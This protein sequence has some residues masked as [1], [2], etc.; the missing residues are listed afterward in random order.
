M[1]YKGSGGVAKKVA[2]VNWGK[3]RIQKKLSEGVFIYDG[4]QSGGFVFYLPLFKSLKPYKTYVPARRNGDKT[5]FFEDEQCY[6]VFDYSNDTMVPFFL[7][8]DRV[9][10]ESFYKF[11]HN[12]RKI[13]KWEYE[14]WKQEQYRRIYTRI[15][16]KETEF[17]DLY[18]S[19]GLDWYKHI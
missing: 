15:T 19:Y 2:T 14:E 11:L 8:F 7:Y 17:Y 6:A 12:I 13:D 4:E 5:A 18:L 9:Y 1:D 16:T 10:T 3:I